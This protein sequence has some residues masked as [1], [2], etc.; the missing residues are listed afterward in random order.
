MTR[1][2]WWVF[3]FLLKEAGFEPVMRSMGSQG[4]RRA[5]DCFEN[6]SDRIAKRHPTL[7]AKIII[8][9]LLSIFW[10]SGKYSCIDMFCTSFF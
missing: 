4:V 9:G 1:R 5:E 6:W 7:S 10:S 3:C 2:L 8:E